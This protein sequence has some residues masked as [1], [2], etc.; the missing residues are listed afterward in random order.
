M[1]VK[2]A[3]ESATLPVRAHETD[4][5][6]DLYAIED[7]TIKP[8][9]VSKIRTGIAIELPKETV[10]LILDRS[11]MG[12]KNIKVMGG[13]IDEGYR[14]EIIVCLS[15]LN[16]Y[17]YSI[18]SGEKIAQ[19]LVIPIITASIE[20]VKELSTTQRNDKGFGSTN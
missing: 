12:A 3:L 1:K 17:N 20:E 9:E 5:G 13:V 15:N 7:T 16:P 10:G 18:K 2:K 14:G 19:L 11:S 6:L 8:L 4:A